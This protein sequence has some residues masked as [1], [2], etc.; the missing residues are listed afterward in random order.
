M[1]IGRKRVP[2][3]GKRKPMASEVGLSLGRL[4]SPEKLNGG[5]TKVREG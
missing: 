3:E 4:R 2:G 1:E 5:G